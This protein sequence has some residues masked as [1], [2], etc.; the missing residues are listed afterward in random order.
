I[1]VIFLAAGNEVE[2]ILAG[3]DLGAV[4]CVVKPYL[5]NELLARIRKA[6]AFQGEQQKF[7]EAVRAFKNN[8][9]ALVSNE[10]RN[11]VTV[12]AG[13]AALLEQKSGRL[14]R[15]VQQA[16]LQEI[17][18]HTDYLAEL[19]DV[20]E[21]LLRSKGMT[22]GVDLVQAVK[23]VV[24]KFRPLTEKKDQR[25]IL[26]TPS[27]PALIVRGYRRDL[28]TAVGYLL[29][30]VHKHTAP[31]GAIRIGVASEDRQARIEVTSKDMT[32]PQN[33]KNSI[34]NHETMDLGLTIAK[35]VAEQQGGSAG[36]ENRFGQG[37]CFW[38]AL[39]L[40]RPVRERQD[41]HSDSRF[42]G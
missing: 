19:T 14:E 37:S 6:L 23:S 38:M 20:F 41:E 18:Q 36:V 7:H 11:H 31:G 12:I 5:L 17:I 32:L 35:W 29:S 1:P 21:N 15:P 3:V 8:F 33:Q 39:P 13:F 40:P 28:F 10:I 27:R 26:K 25:L 16:Y 24:E 30:H 4:D 9:I 2:V 42:D 22:E 34:P